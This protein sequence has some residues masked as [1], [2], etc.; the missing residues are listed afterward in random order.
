MPIF[1]KAEK[2]NLPKLVHRAP[3]CATFK[4]TFFNFSYLANPQAKIIGVNYKFSP[5]EDI[6]YH[7]TGLKCRLHNS[8]QAIEI[9]TSVGFID[10]TQPAVDYFKERPYIEA[11]LPHDFFYPFIRSYQVSSSSSSLQVIFTQKSMCA[12]TS[13]YLLQ[14][15]GV[16]FFTF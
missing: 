14:Q 12:L 5:P 1:R 2:K 3:I 4:K 11:K 10:V 9:S 13:L 16:T 6:V 7:C 15:L 8:S